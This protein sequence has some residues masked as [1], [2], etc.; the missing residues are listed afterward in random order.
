MPLQLPNLD[1]RRYADLVAEARRLIPVH[2]PSWTNHNPSDPGI[3]LLELFAYL[4]EMLL[5]R[6][7]RVTAEHQ[8][9][10]L[11][12][13]NGPDW[14]PGTDLGADIRDTVLAVRARDR[15]VTAADFERLATDDFNHWLAKMKRAQESADSDTLNEWWA[16]TQL[17]RTQPANL[18]STVPAVARARCVPS[19]NLER[20]TEQERTL[21]APAHV[22][23]IVLPEDPDA[24]QPPVL[25]STALRR[26][27]DERR[28]LTTRHHVVGPHYAPVSAELVVAC[29]TG[30]VLDKVKERIAQRLQR[31]LDP[32][33]GAAAGEGWPFGRDVHA[34]ELYEQIEAVEGVDYVVDLMLSSE[35]LDAEQKCAAA[36]PVWHAEGDFVGLALAQ[37][38]LPLPRL[39]AADIV[40]ARSTR[41]VASKVAA[42]LTAAAGSNS[43]ALKRDAKLAIRRFF[44]PLYD[45]PGPAA[46]GSTEL[47]LAD[48]RNTLEALPGV[49]AA[50]LKL[51]A[52]PA[53][54]IMEAET[55]TGLRVEAGELVNWQATVAVEAA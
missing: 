27:L 47:G 53:R 35:C 13:L 54:T 43:A 36:P 39:A 49:T 25:Q 20:G 42:T 18:P 38:H 48:L 16:L 55:V 3:T 17:D 51:Q 9:K 52:H 46:T 40:I 12:L 30:A 50:S 11:K 8:R 32:L 45:G 33:E 6:L 37:H 5:Y 29:D 10:F 34:S 4:S 15:A 22:S 23:L 26:Y 44:H 24:R 41:F 31:F 2:D 7:D 28:T 14:K 1:E 19:R 21:H